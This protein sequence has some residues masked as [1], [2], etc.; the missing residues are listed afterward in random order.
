MRLF[1]KLVPGS[2]YRR[3]GVE[4]DGEKVFFYLGKLSQVNGGFVVPDIPEIGRTNLSLGDP[5]TGKPSLRPNAFLKVESIDADGVCLDDNIFAFTKTG[6]AVEPVEETALVRKAA[7]LHHKR[8]MANISE[9]GGRCVVLAEPERIE[10]NGFSR[11]GSP[12]EIHDDYQGEAKFVST[13][14]TDHGFTVTVEFNGTQS[15]FPATQV[16]HDKYGRS[17]K[18]AAL[19]SRMKPEIDTLHRALADAGIQTPRKDLNVEV[20]IAGWEEMVVLLDSDEAVKALKAIAVDG[21]AH[22]VK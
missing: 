10:L 7:A 9:A 19:R 15:T 5:L 8:L 16:N 18:S 12:W 21:A 22:P 3:K 1:T 4:W 17:G 20:L 2:F 6:L 13:E 14:E 11:L